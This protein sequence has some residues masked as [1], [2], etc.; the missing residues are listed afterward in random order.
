MYRRLEPLSSSVEFPQNC[1]Y[2]PW[3]CDFGTKNRIVLGKQHEAAQ[4]IELEIFQQEHNAE[5]DI[6]ED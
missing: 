6:T 4:R 1:V 5:K 3:F 2:I